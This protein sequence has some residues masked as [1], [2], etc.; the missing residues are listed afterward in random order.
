MMPNYVQAI[1]RASV[2]IFIYPSFVSTAGLHELQGLD[3][4]TWSYITNRAAMRPKN[5]FQ[6]NESWQT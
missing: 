3:V 5:T 2:F 1:L 6:K 4:S